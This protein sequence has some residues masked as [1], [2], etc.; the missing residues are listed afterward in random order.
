MRFRKRLSAAFLAAVMML[1]S[2]QIPGGTSYAAEIADGGITSG[3]DAPIP[4][5]EETEDT[6]TVEGESRQDEEEAAAGDD[7]QSG[8]ES[9]TD[10]E[11]V[12]EEETEAGQVSD[13]DTEEPSED[14]EEPETEEAEEAEAGLKGVY[15]MEDMKLDADGITTYALDSD[16]MDWLYKQML[17]RTVSIDLSEKN[18]TLSSMDEV[19]R[20]LETVAE[21]HPDLYYY[22]GYELQSSTPPISKI[23][24][25]YYDNCDNDTF[26]AKVDEALSYVTDEMSDDVKAAVLHDYLA[27]NVKNDNL[28]MAYNAYGALVNGFAKGRGYAL[29]YKYLLS[30][31]GIESYL[32]TSEKMPDSLYNHTWNMVKLNEKYYHVDVAMDDPQYDMIGRVYHKNLFRSDANLKDHLEW[33]VTFGGDTVDYKATDT[34]YENAFW[35]DSTAPLVVDGTDCYYISE[36]DWDMYRGLK[37]ASF[38]D[39]TNTGTQVARIDSWTMYP[40]EAMPSGSW[41]GYYSGLYMI[42]G[43][44]FY[45]DQDSIYSIKPD[46]TDKRTEFTPEKSDNNRIYYSAY[47]NGE[48]V[49]AMQTSPNLSEWQDVLTAEIKEGGEPEEQGTYKITYILDDGTNDKDNPSSYTAETAEIILKDAAKAGYKFEGWYK[50]AEF[51]EKVTKIPEGSTGDITLYAKWTKKEGLNHANLDYGFH[52]LDYQIVTSHADGKPKVLIF[53][54]YDSFTRNTLQAVQSELDNPD[55]VL[56]G[57]DLYLV[58]TGTYNVIEN[59]SLA[60][61][62][63]EI[64][65]TFDYENDNSDKQQMYKQLSGCF[66][67]SLYNPTIVYIDEEDILQYVYPGTD[68]DTP[69]AAD[70]IAA[71]KKYCDYPSQKPGTYTITYELNGGT[72]SRNNPRTYTA[73]TETI[74]LED[75]THKNSNMKFRG[76]Y[77]DA[78]FTEKVT[79][80]PKGSTGDITLYAKWRKTGEG[81]GLAN[82][83]KTFTALD[84]TT[85]RSKAD[86]RPKLLIFSDFSDKTFD[87]SRTMV[88]NIS[89]RISE[90][91]GIDIYAIDYSMCSRDEVNKIKE[92]CGCDK[93]TFAY[94]EETDGAQA[95]LSEY[96]YVA[97]IS[98]SEAYPPTICYIDENDILQW[99][100][101]SSRDFN[102]TVSEVLASL[103][104]YC[105]PSE[106]E[107]TFDITYVLDGGTNDKD[108]PSSYTPE[109]ETIVLKDASKMNFK[110]EGWYKDAKFQ[111]KVTQIP[112]GSTGDITLYAKWS[113]TAGKDGVN[114]ENPYYSLTT[115]DGEEVSTKA[116][117]KPKVL[118]FFRPGCFNCQ[119]TN[120]GLSENIKSFDGVDI[121][122]IEISGAAKEDVANFKKTYGCDEIIYCYDEEGENNSYFYKYAEIAQVDGTALTPLIVYI[123]SQNRV[124]YGSYGLRSYTEILTNLV[125]YCDYNYG[126]AEGIYKIT[127]E[128]N[129]GTNSGKNP[130]VYAADSQTIVLQ[131][132]LKAGYLFD[133]WYKD[134]EFKEKVT[135]IP[136]GSTGD[137]T[138]YAKWQK[139]LSAANPEYTLT[140]LDDEKVS[141]RADGKPKILFF[142]STTCGYCRT[143]N[144]ELRDHIEEFD[145]VDIY[146]IE[147]FLGKTK[148][149]VAQFKKDNGCDE[150]TYCYD[151]DGTN[152]KCVWDYVHML[153]LDNYGQVNTPVIVYIDSKNRVQ[154]GTAGGRSWTQIL[155]DLQK[156]CGNDDYYWINYELDGGENDSENPE[157]YKSDGDTITLKD[158]VKEGYKFRGWYKDAEF[159]EK[160]TQIP[161][162]STGDIT[163]YAKWIKA[164]DGLGVANLDRTFTALDGTKLSSRA[165]GKAKLLVFVCKVDERDT[166]ASDAVKDI[167][168]SISKFT[169]VDIY[170]IDYDQNSKEDVSGYKDLYG[171]DEMTFAYD[172]STGTRDILVEYLKAAG[173]QTMW[174]T[175]P[176]ICY[177]D[178]YDMLQWITQG[179]ISAQTVLDNLDIYCDYSPEDYVPMPSGT[180]KIAYEL[181]GGT[182]STE[183][184]ATYTTD[185]ET[186]TLA[187]AVREGYIFEGWYKDAGFKER[188]TQ[189]VKGS[190]GNIRL[191]AKW[192]EEGT[193]DDPDDPNDPNDQDDTGVYQ[194][195]FNVQGHGTAPQTLADIK[196]GSTIDRPEEP[197]ADGYRFDGW[198]KDPACTKPWDFATDIVQSNLTLYA[199]WLGMSSD[200]EFA[201]Q[202]IS[203]LYYNGKAQKPAVSVYD[204]NTLLKAGK[205]YTVTYYNNINVNKDG[206]LKGEIFNTALPYVEITGKGNYKETVKINFNILPASIGNDSRPA[207]GVTLKLNDQ[208]VKA[209]KEQKPFGSIKY[210]RNLKEGTDYELELMAVSVRDQSNT[211]IN[212]TV[213][214]TGAKVPANYSGEFM[215]TVTGTGNYTG[216]ISRMVYVADKAHLMK[217]MKITLGKDLKNIPYTGSEIELKA[218]QKAKPANDEFVVTYGRTL[219]NPGVDY[220]VSYNNNVGAGKAELVVT[221]K[222][223]YVGS[224]TATF[225]IKGKT[226][227]NGTVTVTGLQDQA[228]TGRAIVQNADLTWKADGAKLVYGVDYTVSYSKNINKG[229]ATVTFTG[230]AKAGYSG[231]ISKKFK[232]GAADISEVTRAASMK[233]ITLPYTKAGVKPVDEIILTNERGIRLSNGKDYTLAYKNNKAVANAAA[234]NAPTVTVKGKG[235]Y[236]GS[237]DEKF[238]IERA[239]LR[240]ENITIEC[241]QTAYNSKKAADYE[242]KPAVTIK[243]G[244]A[245]LKAGTDYEISYVR[246]TQ[247]AFEE[248]ADSGMAGGLK[249]VAVITAKEGSAYSMQGSFEVPLEIYKEKLTKNNLQVDIGKAVYTGGQ[250]RPQVTVTY[251]GESGNR[252]LIEGRDYT[253]IYGANTASGKNKGSVTIKGLAPEFGG[254]VTYK[255]E[256]IRKDLKYN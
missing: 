182:N 37:K 8:D 166:A 201:V 34:K 17:E 154:Y 169:G 174:T 183:N 184:P 181:N 6:A 218:A 4:A 60:V 175:P 158:P 70:I 145:G 240:G 131:E 109:T 232:I 195:V 51:E 209:N 185:T 115:L 244:K 11:N 46:G 105:Y 108:N 96:L 100:S 176:V 55:S 126:D 204:E 224:K 101:H 198:F 53:G 250:V 72:N 68:W 247:A 89:N 107:E 35:V 140:T 26:N 49:Y 222:N 164:G 78:E 173:Q 77:K 86:G 197:T 9:Q 1:S 47:R 241:A 214:F 95:V 226:F 138:L 238:T 99:I 39:I 117:G 83:D 36:A 50:D 16:L 111:E 219:L 103:K 211:E 43:R 234:G 225:T 156:Y 58:G 172:T 203:N 23:Y 22:K 71:L 114:A 32:V 144:Q 228:Y 2:V 194:V 133:G 123:D 15:K 187:D 52:K 202:E 242:Y 18:C 137:I 90:F 124:Q 25:S 136:K 118:F 62:S 42:N 56:H 191:Y 179:K 155:E 208:L 102:E 59:L 192:R 128:L 160:V 206:V 106:T 41:T 13:E 253:L 130:S 200:G 217:N 252:T 45:N 171:C 146:A 91:D 248:Y 21:E 142:L 167:S 220:D 76:W 227:A 73:E 243:D 205:D 80:I 193:P 149:E 246:N 132:A 210:G 236:S 235:N 57:V 180:Y 230:K 121:Y 81:F 237:F 199:K 221:G 139:R 189:I 153:N 3:Q 188:V 251:K 97:G 61:P 120:F 69:T 29:A 256:I 177:I 254:S 94:D 27:I 119:Q 127:Y 19:R 229:T 150:I 33:K 143:T 67:D 104:K 66:D 113:R 28:V 129:G 196:A 93:I 239:D 125:D 31:V 148:E 147:A 64:I 159:T 178:E 10:D 135:Q 30:Q 190:T 116:D 207:A 168:Q 245:K 40:D 141:T 38:S 165:N 213:A 233:A 75:A 186:I 223:G 151:T 74:V 152:K 79:Q 82:L 65:Y 215:L 163:L 12:S 88:K 44:L 63:D 14:T 92:E 231:K 112:K 170:V 110:F 157:T 212:N 24:I 48:V 216:S 87:R 122:A 162:G 255:F 20:L 98:T 161:K 84:G 5:A 249:P 134:A 7:S 85:I 54:T